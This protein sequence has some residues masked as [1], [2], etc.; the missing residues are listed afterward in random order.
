M[1]VLWCQS[2][3]DDRAPIETLC[4]ILIIKQFCE[5]EAETFDPILS[6]KID[7]RECCKAAVRRT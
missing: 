7:S 4:K 2:S 5:G 6:R 3:Y 1:I